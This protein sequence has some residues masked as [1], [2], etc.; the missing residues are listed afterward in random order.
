[1]QEGKLEF[2]FDPLPSEKLDKQE[3]GL[4]MPNGMTLVDFAVEDD[5]HGYTYLIQIKD[6]S[7]ANP[8][9]VNSVQI[10]QD[11]VNKLNTDELFDKLVPNARDSYCYLHL[12]NRDTNKMVFI[13]I[14]GI[15]KQYV[16]NYILMNFKDKLFAK[17][18][19]EAHIPWQRNHIQDCIV[20]LAED[21][22]YVFPNFKVRRK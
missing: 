16:N 11:F 19:F 14:L 22:S 21:F 3:K 4:Q 13:V 6:P 12:M 7:S 5:T 8:Q 9:F 17:I 2:N 18:K 1:M 15:E 20:V 10:Q